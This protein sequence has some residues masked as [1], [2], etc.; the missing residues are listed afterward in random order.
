VMSFVEVP[1]RNVTSA[2]INE[3]NVYHIIKTDV[4]QLRESSAWKA[5]AV[6]SRTDMRRC[7]KT[8]IDSGCNRSIFTNRSCG[9]GD[10]YEVIGSGT[11]YACYCKI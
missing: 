1:I 6:R 8:L 7:R 3:D 9:S 4:S 2:S 11:L 10:E 5:M